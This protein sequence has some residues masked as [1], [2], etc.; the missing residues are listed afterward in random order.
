MG[1]DASARSQGLIIGLLNSAAEAFLLG[2]FHHRQE[3][4]DVEAQ[5]TVKTVEQEQVA[6][7]VVA[8][9]ADSTADDR[10]VPFGFAQG[11]LSVRR[12]RCRS[13]DRRDRG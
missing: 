10:P 7:G 3:E 9:I 12:R 11:R 6:E 1:Q 13:C 4:V 8:T 2:E 5:D